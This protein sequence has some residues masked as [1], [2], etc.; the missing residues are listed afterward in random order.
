MR[1]GTFVHPK[2]GHQLYEDWQ[3]QALASYIRDH[4]RRG[5]PQRWLS[6]LETAEIVC[7]LIDR[8]QPTCE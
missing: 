6:D 2:D 4:L 8:E 1:I 3:V 7:E 5:T